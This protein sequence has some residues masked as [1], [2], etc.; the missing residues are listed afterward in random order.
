[1]VWFWLNHF[2]VYPVKAN[3]RWLVADYEERA[4]RPHALGHF[5]DLVMATLDHPAMLQ[6][7]DNAQNAAGH[8]NENYA[9]ELMELHTLGVDGGYTQQDVQALARVLTGVGINASRMAPKLRPEWQRL[10]GAPVPSSSIRRATI[11]R[12]NAARR[13]IEGRGFAEVEQAVDLLVRQPAC[14]RFMSRQARVYFVADDPPAQLVE[15]MAQ[16]FQSTDGDIA[17]VL[18]TMLDAPRVRRLARHQVQGS[19]ALR[20]VG[21]AARLRRR[22]RSSTPT[23]SST[24]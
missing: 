17:A 8:V 6:Y 10:Y 7:L 11:S 15:H 13:D 2:S 22:A 14:A 18:R 4:I 5:R 1:M 16:T 19:D 21:A 24:G 3:L 12:A 23:R 20:G 9:R